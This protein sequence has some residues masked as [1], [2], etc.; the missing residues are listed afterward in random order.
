MNRVGRLYYDGTS[1]NTPCPD[2]DSSLLTGGR[3]GLR[4]VG[5]GPADGLPKRIGEGGRSDGA[6][7][8]RRS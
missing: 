7:A 6:D 3:T 5:Y 8:V 1:C 4:Y 2:V